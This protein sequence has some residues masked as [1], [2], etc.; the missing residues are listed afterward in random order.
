MDMGAKK[1]VN[2]GAKYALVCVCPLLIPTPFSE[3]TLGISLA[4]GIVLRS[5]NRKHG[6]RLPIRT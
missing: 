2:T 6:K 4:L 1:I 3:V 5:K